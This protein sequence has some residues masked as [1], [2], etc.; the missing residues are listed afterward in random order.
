MRLLA[1]QTLRMDQS[2]VLAYIVSLVAC[3][4]VARKRWRV[5]EYQI[6]LNVL[7]FVDSD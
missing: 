2:V 5:L 3:E 6:L 4:V 7:Q 1:R